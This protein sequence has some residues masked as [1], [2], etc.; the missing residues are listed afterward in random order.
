[1]A[2]LDTGG[3]TNGPAFSPQEYQTLFLEIGGTLMTEVQSI[4]VVRTD[5]GADVMTLA[6]D[7]AGRVKGAA[8]A[9]VTFKG[10][11]PYNPQ[12]DVTG[13]GFQNGGMMAG[14]ASGGSVLSGFQNGLTPLDQTM[15]TSI[16][17]YGAQPVQFAILVG[18]PAVQQL[19]FKGYIHEITVDASIGKPTDFT[20]KAS[21]Q[22]SIFA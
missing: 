19:V 15:L 11:V 7:Y 3:F 14:A 9:D 22:F 10:V 6:R 4:S 20:C 2:T 12:G 8:K 1:M 18:S 17:T 13:A 16:N 5:G 21:G